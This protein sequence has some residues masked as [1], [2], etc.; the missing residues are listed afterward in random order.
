MNELY[1]GQWLS[2]DIINT[3]FEMVELYAIQQNEIAKSHTP[4]TIPTGYNRITTTT[5][6]SINLST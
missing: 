4:C 2:M 1:P 3:F 6:I 5:Y